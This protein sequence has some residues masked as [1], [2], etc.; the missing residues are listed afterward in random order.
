MKQEQFFKLVEHNED[1]N[2]I[3]APAKPC[4]RLS[5]KLDEIRFSVSIRGFVPYEPWAQQLSSKLVERTVE[6]PDKENRTGRLPF[7]K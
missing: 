1:F 3:F 4:N 5:K 2:V 6:T 7:S